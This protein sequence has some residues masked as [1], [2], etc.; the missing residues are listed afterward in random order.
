MAELHIYGANYSPVNMEE[1]EEELQKHNIYYHGPYAPKDLPS[2]LSQT[3]VGVVPSR[4]DNFPTVVREFFHA[5]VPVV[6]SEEG[7]IPE[8]VRQDISGRLFES[9]NVCMLQSELQRIIDAPDL[10]DGY[11]S[12][13]EPQFSIETDA[14]ELLDLYRRAL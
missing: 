2:I 11:K 12:N 9:Q 4:S 13:I 1:H 14:I 7:G 3:D 10:I 5:G 6:A 8:L